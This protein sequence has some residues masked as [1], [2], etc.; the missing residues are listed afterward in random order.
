ME[1]VEDRSGPKNDLKQPRRVTGDTK[2]TH[3]TLNAECR[4]RCSSKTRNVMSS[5]DTRRANT[6]GDRPRKRA[7]FT[8]E[9]GMPLEQI[10]HFK[11]G[12]RGGSRERGV[13]TH[14]ALSTSTSLP[15][16]KPYKNQETGGVCQGSNDREKN[17]PCESKE[18]RVSALEK[19]D[20]TLWEIFEGDITSNL[21]PICS[22]GYTKGFTSNG[23]D[24]RS[25][26]GTKA[27]MESAR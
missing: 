18:V 14:T 12:F 22:K 27:K 9:L 20:S 15:I 16:T 19:G 3:A 7:R 6:E 11:S 24:N 5:K 21:C 1:V 26:Q 25:L 8:D 17:Q 10:Y 23:E 13:K 2:N 4:E